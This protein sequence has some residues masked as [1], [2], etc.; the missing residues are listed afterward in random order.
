MLRVL[1]LSAAVM[2]ATILVL[3]PFSDQRGELE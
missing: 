3:P 2:A 1:R